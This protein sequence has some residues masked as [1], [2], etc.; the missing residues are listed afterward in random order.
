MK[1]LKID[2]TGQSRHPE[3]WTTI[4]SSAELN[5]EWKIDHSMKGLIWPSK[6]KKNSGHG[7]D[8]TTTTTSLGRLKKAP[9]T[10]SLS[11]SASSLMMGKKHGSPIGKQN[12]IEK[13]VLN[14]P[15]GGNELLADGSGGR[16]KSSATLS[17]RR[18]SN[19][20]PSNRRAS[21]SIYLSDSHEISLKSVNSASH[22]DEDASTRSSGSSKHIATP[23]SDTDTNVD[24]TEIGS[25][26]ETLM[27]KSFQSTVANEA[28]NSDKISASEQNM[29]ATGTTIDSKISLN[30]DNYD[31]VVFKT[32]WLNRS[33]GST[34]LS[35][36]SSTH[37][38][39]S[40]L[41]PGG[42][43]HRESR[44]YHDPTE[45]QVPVPD[46]RIY[47]AQLKGPILSL[48]KSGLPSNVK[49]FDPTVQGSKDETPTPSPTNQSTET[50]TKQTQ[51]QK[52]ESSKIRYLSEK[53]PHPGLKL[54]N[55]GKI[56]AG[57]VESLCHAILFSHPEAGEN[58]SKNQRTIINLILVL[59]LLDN[60]NKFLR[61]FNQFGLTFTKHSSKVS[62]KSFQYHSVSPIVDNL[63][64]E[65]LG[66]VVKTT[67]DMFP[68]FV[69]DDRMF[70]EIIQLLDVI[71]LHNDEISNHLK[72]AVAD[73]H[74]QLSKLT[75][76]S[77]GTT[78]SGNKLKG[79]DHE[80]K[81]LLDEILNVEDFLK[82]NIDKVATEIHEINLKFDQSW[83]PR[84]DYSLLYDSKFIN[85]SIVA[86]NPLTFNNNVNVHFLGRL[87]I[88]H[89]FSND[90]KICSDSK[91]RAKVLT[92]W[93][94][95]GVKFE[96]LG[97]MV[98]WLA[99][100]TIICSVPILRLASLWTQVPEN[101]LKTIVKD[102]IP[103]IAQLDRRHLSSKST[104]S[105]F[106]L[107][108]PNLDNPFIKSNV[109]SY[110]G[111]LIIH[112][113]DLMPETKLKYL[114][115]KINRTKNAFH[116]WQQR[117][118]GNSVQSKD[119]PSSFNDIDPSKSKIYQ[120][121]KFH[122]GQPN[123]SIK[124]IMGMSVQFERPTVD[125]AYYSSIGSQRSPLSTGGYLPILFNEVYPNYSLF[126][127]KALIGAAGA[128]EGS[129][130]SRESTNQSKSSLRRSKAFITDDVPLRTVDSTLSDGPDTTQITGLVNIDVPLVKEIS[131]KQSNRQH[132]LKCIR[133]AFNIDSDVFHVSDDL[134]F[135]SVNDLEATSRPSS[136]V[137]ETPKRFSQ[138]SSGNGNLSNTRDSQDATNRLSKT[139]DNLDFFNNI[140]TVS[141]PLKE[142]LIEVALKSGSLDKIY[143]L[144]VLTAS[145]FSKM[146]DTKDL[147][148]YYHHIKHKNLRQTSFMAEDSV[149]LLDY[150][151]VKLNMDMDVFTETFF[152][153]Y[154][155]F[156]TTTS[157]IENLARRYVGAQSC[158]F[159]IAQFL[160]TSPRKS[161]GAFNE[162]KFP[163]WDAKVPYNEHINTV[164]WAKI[165]VGAAEAM[166]N[167]VKH[168]YADFTDDL[169]ANSTILDFLK[170]MEQDV[171]SE[172]PI[173]SIQLKE[174]YFDDH[175]ETENLISRLLTLF[176]EIR[177]YYQKQLYRPLN[178]D[179]NCRKV[180]SLL[181]S[182]HSMSF[183]DF[184]GYL[185]SNDYED[186]MIDNLHAMKPDDIEG[187]M[188]WVYSLDSFISK[189]FDMVSKKDW[190]TT[191][192]ILELFS[193]ESL[194]SLFCLP[195]HS[196]SYD[197]VTSGTSQLEDLEILDVFSWISN[198]VANAGSGNVV[199]LEK[200]PAPVRLLIKLHISLSN[201]FKV[202]IT[203]FRKSS[204]DR[205]KTCALVM[206]ILSYV[207]WKNSSLDLFQPE[208]D[209]DQ[210]GIS[211]HIPCFI[212][213]AITGAIVSP[214]S[215]YYE[216][217]WSACHD[218]L[219]PSKSKS[220]FSIGSILADVDE[221]TIKSFIDLDG[222]Y[223]S[224][225]RNLCP[226]PGWIISRLLEI[227]QFV[228]NMSIM[229]SK[230][231]NFDKRRFINNIIANTLDLVPS[232][233]NGSTD[234][235]QAP[236]GISLFQTLHDSGNKF[237]RAARNHAISESK[238]M[239]YQERGFFNEILIKEVEKIKRDHKKIEVLSALERDNK[240]SAVVQQ[241]VERKQ[242]SSV[243]IPS[244]QMNLAGSSNTST[245]SS[246]GSAQARD[247]R[248]SVASSNA[249]SSVISN[250]G[251]TPMGK[252]LGGFFRRPFSIGGFN[253][254]ASNS[255][256]SSILI[257]GVQDDGSV[258]SDNLP[259]LDLSLMQDQKSAVTIRTFEIKSILEAINHNKSSAH[260]FSFKILMQDG[261]EHIFQAT[262]AK[263]LSEWMKLINASKRYAFHS[264]KFKGKTHN[265][266][267]G[268]P[269]EDICEREG[270]LIPTIV[271]KL[272][273][274]IE[275]RGLD[276][277]G[278]YRIPG[279][280]GSVNALKGAFDEE[281]AVGNSF[282][283]E[284]DRWFEINAIAGCFK[285]YLRELPDCLFSNTRVGDFAELAFELKTSQISIQQY[286]VKM[287]ELLQELPP[288]YYQTLKR[289]FYHLHKVHSH[290]D[291]NRMDASNLAIV[292]S[293]S[294]INQEDLASSMGPTLGAVQSILQHFIRD[295]DDYFTI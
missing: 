226:C 260:S 14:S 79:F 220:S 158:A 146:I 35:G 88:C 86:L 237:K 241:M 109:I 51:S 124:D 195:L 80:S 244:L 76:F 37:Q 66:L 273:E 78:S 168:H 292:F 153:S 6:N 257:P 276:E 102:W 4:E 151:F 40:G 97:D 229:N 19:S 84:F 23:E 74:N 166:L 89:L 269:L 248:S 286:K 82:T 216:H 155:S 58:D 143:D 150:A 198:S 197:I 179:R 135:K 169:S 218:M 123:L 239:R 280:V 139:L 279:S 194:T 107:A 52:P 157:V 204:E 115:R 186:P 156:A 234:E 77:R 177:T 83:A 247:K 181:G 271:V 167:L 129:Q 255:S 36:S 2:N 212:E 50:L 250:S 242:R 191:F 219:T 31:S 103:T 223:T 122:L 136:V 258:S 263:D 59:P 28:P 243:I 70:Q 85:T 256:L 187:L 253:S 254:S 104:S 69:L 13:N 230:L 141:D 60:F 160:N 87:L 199:L 8:D 203:D 173:R 71:S 117:L 189:K 171:T 213:T 284:D 134:I 54:D 232:S 145:I 64:T 16:R 206:Q 5:L 176:N 267:F 45:L 127:Q 288:C 159:A 228:P 63:M 147:E 131:T 48:F 95:F 231:I 251:H 110:F 120:F 211:P 53:H 214:E 91:L 73:K 270:T 246:T 275:M 154:K 193:F 128:L 165:Q 295:P 116:K 24:E 15:L 291:N 46:Y 98:S 132:L 105:V 261:H 148:K 140:V 12:V 133:D 9:S 235:S 118:G 225:A 114:E 130:Q 184:S 92:K 285:M 224:R 7:S 3:F 172:W 121:W 68:S 278:L 39:R 227:S 30:K 293:M 47:R 27:R 57:D 33:Q 10:R 289:I 32:G 94:E 101:I 43:S 233:E 265:K 210:N 208:E 281:G 252:K 49:Y 202:E 205:V 144:L 62:N 183:T 259:T 25:Q 106:I 41:Y 209:S 90:R 137:I 152:N 217:A 162:T 1:L 238:A 29:T 282:T 75:A 272:L 236:F 245:P 262:S 38:L 21:K 26:S 96:H 178:I 175:V 99:V 72:M 161:D 268:V 164:F 287:N 249:R 18:P 93:V 266:M 125:Q 55:E 112:A 264:K 170:V 207:R 222:A 119:V 149:G 200:L 163:V 182:F 290:M 240:R 142:S 65:R 113:D 22:K 56:V 215:R 221:L 111:D 283:L 100:A 61:M 11:P 185:S 42:N 126:P 108:P 196:K 67:L 34:H 81:T 294:F 188:K 274:E 277:V 180:S 192:Q 44:L 174:K 20:N 201:L 138:H 190:F 17:M